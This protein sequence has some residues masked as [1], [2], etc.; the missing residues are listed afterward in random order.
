MA[1]DISLTNG[2]SGAP[3][4]RFDSPNNVFC[5]IHIGGVF[6][7]ELATAKYQILTTI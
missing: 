5:G 3:I 4:F 1:Y 2:S 6:A 7:F